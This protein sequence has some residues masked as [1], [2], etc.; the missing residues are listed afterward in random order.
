MLS[1]LEANAV[2]LA[3]PAEVIAGYARECHAQVG[4]LISIQLSQIAHGTKPGS[5]EES[6]AL[7]ALDIFNEQLDSFVAFET[8]CNEGTEGD[9][10][11]I[12]Y[13]RGYSVETLRFAKA[14]R[15]D[16]SV[17]GTPECAYLRSTR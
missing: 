3:S 1:G 6:E 17:D 2:T 13:S 7:R 5:K 16:V 15:A 8:G 10:K 14:H 9:D 4:A 11:F 12:C